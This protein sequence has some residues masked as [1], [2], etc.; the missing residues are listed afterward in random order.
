M[1]R[2]RVRVASY[3]PAKHQC[4]GEVAGYCA[5]GVWHSIAGAL[6]TVRER[7][8]LERSHFHD[9]GFV[10]LKPIKRV[11]TEVPNERLESLPPGA[12]LA[13]ILGMDSSSAEA[14]LR[15][16]RS[17]EL[18]SRPRLR[19]PPHASAVC[20]RKTVPTLPLTTPAHRLEPGDQP[21]DL[22]YQEARHEPH[23]ERH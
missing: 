13:R 15:T 21:P 6:S 3:A 19:P 23:R 10:C 22:R 9:T 17:G 5:D 12:V 4:V 16:T 20:F 18:D 11:A 2:R 14:L 7:Y 8:R 1:W